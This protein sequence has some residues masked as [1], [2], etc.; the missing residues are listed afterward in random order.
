M[1][2]LKKIHNLTKAIVLLGAVEIV[3]SLIWF[4]FYKDP[5]QG[6]LYICGGLIIFVF[7][8][9]YQWMKNFQRVVKETERKLIDIQVWIT[10]EE[11]NKI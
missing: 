2:N 10:N 3:S 8:Y 7:A 9:I 11:H 4:G 5:S 6:V 1:I